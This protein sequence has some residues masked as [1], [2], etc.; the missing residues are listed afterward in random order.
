[1]SAYLDS[2]FGLRGSTALVTGGGKGL[3]RMISEALLQAGASV[4]ISS[5]SSEDCKDAAL[6]MSA[7]G[8]CYAFPH[9]LSDLQGIEPLPLAASGENEN[10]YEECLSCQ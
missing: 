3:G 5:R 4:A 6:E 7:F 1:M 2:L 9:D 8:E 10:D